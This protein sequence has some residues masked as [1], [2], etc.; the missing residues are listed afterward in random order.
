MATRGHD[1]PAP[2]HNPNNPPASLYEFRDLCWTCNDAVQCL[3]RST[4]RRPVLFCEQFDDY[5]PVTRLIR[6]RPAQARAEARSDLKGI[7]MNCDEQVLCGRGRTE[8]AIQF[9]EQYA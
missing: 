6:Q 8:P 5:T 3:D 1:A 7:C 4:L 2:M 9:C